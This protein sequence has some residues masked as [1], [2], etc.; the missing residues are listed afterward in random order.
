MMNHETSEKRPELQNSLISD[1][2][3]EIRPYQSLGGAYDQLLGQLIQLCG[4]NEN[5]ILYLRL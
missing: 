4:L 2:R 3:K 1:D 5:V